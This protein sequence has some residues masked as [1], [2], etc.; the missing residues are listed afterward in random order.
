M[1]INR[2]IVSVAKKILPYQATLVPEKRQEL[3]TEGGL[4]V[5]KNKRKI[6]E[7]VESLMKKGI[8]VS[9]FIDPDK[10]EI[11]AAKE[12]GAEIIEIHTGLYSEAVKK[13]IYEENMRG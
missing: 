5:Y 3:T 6:G 4:S 8:K 9:L 13:I 1:S 11:K 7:V 2:G 12:I 10:R